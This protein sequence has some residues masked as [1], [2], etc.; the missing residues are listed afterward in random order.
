MSHIEGAVFLFLS[1]CCEE[2]EAVTSTRSMVLS[3][4]GAWRRPP[5][6]PVPTSVCSAG[7]MYLKNSAAAKF[8]ASFTKLEEDCGLGQCN[9][10]DFE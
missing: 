9:R 8:R 2:E 1:L 6:S 7:G 5:A 10:Q 3:L 4:T